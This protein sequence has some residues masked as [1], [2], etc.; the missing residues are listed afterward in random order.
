[1]PEVH[2]HSAPRA[3]LEPA[4]PHRAFALEVRDL[5]AGYPG[6][7]PAIEAVTLAVAEGELVGLIGPNGAGKSTLFKA[8]L[9]LVHPQRGDVRVFGRP[10]AQAR[11]DVAYMPQVEEVDCRAR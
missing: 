4:H 6:R 2:E 8:I 3:V 10:L 7:P 11:D 5:C 9:G 1:M